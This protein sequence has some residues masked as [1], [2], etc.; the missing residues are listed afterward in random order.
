MHPCY[1]PLSD[2]K[3]QFASC[4]KPQVLAHPVSAWIVIGL[5]QSRFSVARFF[6]PHTRKIL[7]RKTRILSDYAETRNESGFGASLDPESFRA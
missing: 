5:R 7:R 3:P 1:A 4:R 2:N 6:L